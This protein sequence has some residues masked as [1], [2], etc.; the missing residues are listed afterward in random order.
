MA[1]NGRD[2]KLYPLASP[3][4]GE[5]GAKWTRVFDPEFKS[6]LSSRRDR[7]ATLAGHLHGG[8]PGGMPPLTDAQINAAGGPHFPVANAHVG[9]GLA[10]GGGGA[11]PVAAAG[12]VAESQ[13]AF[14][15]RSEE[16]VTEIR[17]HIP[18]VG[19]QEAIDRMVAALRSRDW[20]NGAPILTAAYPADYHIVA[21]RGQPLQG[22][23]LHRYQKCGN[24]LGRHVYYMVENSY[25]KL[26]TDGAL[27][28][29]HH[30]LVWTTLKIE[31]VT[32]GRS[33]VIDLKE[34]INTISRE[35]PDPKT[36]EQKRRKLL[37]LITF[38]QPIYDRAVAELAHAS[39]QLRDAAGLPD[40]DKTCDALQELWEA[41]YD[42]G[43][44]VDK[45][46]TAHGSRGLRADG[47]SLQAEQR[48]DAS[49]VMFS[50]MSEAARCDDGYLSDA[51]C[52]DIMLSQLRSGGGSSLHGE[53]FC[54]NCLGWGHT[55]NREGQ[56]YCVS[57]RKDR[58]MTE[59]AEALLDKDRQANKAGGRSLARP[60]S[61]QM[62][63]PTPSGSRPG[64]GWS[65]PP[66]R[67]SY[68]PRGTQLRGSQRKPPSAD[69]AEPEEDEDEPVPC[70]MSADGTVRD[71]DGNVLAAAAEGASP[72]VNSAEP[73][74]L[75]FSSS[76]G[77]YSLESSEPG[78]GV[79]DAPGGPDDLAPADFD[80]ADPWAAEEKKKKEEGAK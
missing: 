66:S 30:D 25:G 22:N 24:S 70:T 10:A 7:H 63:A 64:A 1:D 62:P 35:R 26:K 27:A 11:G 55:K 49:N 2:T 58:N 19:I 6:G 29:E 4:L 80:E 37:S 75:E 46:A 20:A 40:F 28:G 45:A 31:V 61:R 50:L 71:L 67:P 14:N 36:P 9:A 52:I 76:M 3:F 48:L 54:W 72:E 21:L 15:M 16:L 12:M 18:V 56:P 8:D 69:S 73:I 57:P 39:P 51:E 17:R 41:Y 42:K 33:T 68:R 59:A 74:P 32:I 43:L 79:E 23:E 13:A 78:Q 60:P 5:R 47:M 38:P 44:I 77:M 53:A 65:R 34:R